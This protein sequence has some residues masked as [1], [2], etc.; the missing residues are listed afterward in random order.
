MIYLYIYVSVLTNDKIMASVFLIV[1][2]NIR[3]LR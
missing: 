2:I 1:K 3:C